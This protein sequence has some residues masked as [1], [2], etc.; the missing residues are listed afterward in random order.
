M[1]SKGSCFESAASGWN[2]GRQEL[3][4]LGSRGGAGMTKRRRVGTEGGL[5]TKG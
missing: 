1:S 2:A 4:E 5:E 3:G